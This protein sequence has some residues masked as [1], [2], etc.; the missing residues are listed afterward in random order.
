[1]FAHKAFTTTMYAVHCTVKISSFI[2]SNND[3]VCEKV[4][5]SQVFLSWIEWDGNFGKN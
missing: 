2:H 3:S 4:K 1:M 5:G